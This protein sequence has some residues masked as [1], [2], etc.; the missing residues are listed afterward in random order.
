MNL[1]MEFNITESYKNNLSKHFFFIT[2]YL[3]HIVCIKK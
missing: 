3:I 1:I 2:A